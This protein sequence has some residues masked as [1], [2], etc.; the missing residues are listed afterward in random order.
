MALVGIS[1]PVLAGTIPAQLPDPDGK[2]GD[3]AKPIKVFILVGDESV[4]EEGVVTGRTDGVHEA[5]FPNAKPTPDEERKHVNCAVYQGAWSPEADYGIIKPLAT[6]L[7]EIGDQRT[8]RI[9]PKARGREPVPMT[10]FPESAMKPG[11]TTVLRGFIEVKEAGEYEF[12]PGEDESAF[13]LTT[14]EGEE[15]YRRDPGQAR[16]RIKA[17]SLE[18]KKRYAFQTVFFKQP[19]HAFRLP[20]INKP[21]TLETVV[22]QNSGYSF[23]KD[24]DGEWVT[25]DDVVLYDAHPIHNNTEAPARPLTCMTTVQIGPEGGERMGVDLMLGHVLGDAIGEPVMILRFATRHPNW[26]SRGSRD[27]SHDFRPPSSGGGSDLA[28]SWDVIHFNFGVWDATYREASSKYFS[29]HNITSVEDFE[30]NLRT[31][32]A[33]MKKTGATLV[34]GAATP[35]WEGEPGKPNGD[36]D[37]YNRV[38]EKV[39]KENGVIINDLNA[40]VRRQGFPKSNNVHSVGNLAPKV[41]ETVLAALEK[42]ENPTKPLPRVL[43]IGDSITGS[44]WEGVKKSFDGKAVIFKN[45][46]NGEDT[47]N[48]LERMDEWL[49][50]DRYLLNGQSYLELVDG[51]RKAL[52]DELERVY[53]GDV[54]QGAE[55]AGLVWFQGIADGEWDS[56]AAEYE[57]HLA[58]LIGDLR[59]DLNAPE[60]PV[61]VGALARAGTPM[62]PNQQKVFDAQM[63]VGDPE[64][65]PEFAG[66]VISIDTRPMIR[67][68]E[69]LPGGRDRYNGNAE[70]YL[71]IGKA[72]GEAMIRLLK[73]GDVPA[74]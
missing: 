69:E 18:P 30:K 59:K 1:L 3:A 65:H 71:G 33:K 55:L 54:S 43:F 22:A 57:K 52:G 70:S 31:L 53:P 16:A 29:G 34:W 60:L 61:V 17:V 50:L 42:R 32:V 37:A 5:F 46:G 48:G 11:H 20:R 27:L 74:K 41:T 36:E 66:N 45:P 47:W 64:K 15:V 12:R 7:V 63:A 8:R 73:D 67:P 68:A 4:L 44:Y 19:G 49:E 23:L 25:R 40:E 6:G 72:M 35:V 51:V 24:K 9:D 28:G 26:F 58:H 21:G 14:L 2:Q 10:P 56:K 13:N 39:M 38:A 62:N